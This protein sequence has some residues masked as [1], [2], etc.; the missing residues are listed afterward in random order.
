[1]TPSKVTSPEKPLLQSMPPSAR[2][3]SGRV[4]GVFVPPGLMSTVPVAA[5][6]VPPH[7]HVAPDGPPAP[8]TAVALAGPATVAA[9]ATAATNMPIAR[10]SMRPPVRSPNYTAR[11]IIHRFY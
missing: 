3:L 10:L 11:L 5:S 6:G 1:M 8:E 7:V 2:I 4:L 9:T